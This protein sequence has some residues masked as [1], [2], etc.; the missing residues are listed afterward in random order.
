[1]VHGG[2]STVG[3]VLAAVVLALGLVT[4]CGGG[5]GGTS[6]GGGTPAPAVPS[7]KAG[8]ASFAD[9]AGL[10]PSAAVDDGAHVVFED[11]TGLAKAGA[12]R[13]D[14]SDPD[15]EGSEYTRALDELTKATGIGGV[16]FDGGRCGEC[17]PKAYAAD[18]RAA[19]GFDPLAADRA[20]LVGQ[21]PRELTLL[22]GGID[23]GALADAFEG[24]PTYAVVRTG[25]AV[26]IDSNCEPAR[27]RCVEAGTR[28][29]LG[30]GLHLWSDGA[31]TAI[32]FDPG[33]VTGVAD[34][35]TGKP[36]AEG[37]PADDPVRT[38]LGWADELELVSGAGSRPD[39]PGD[40]PLG[41][42]ADLP[43]A[44]GAPEAVAALLG[45]GP[46][47][48]G[49]GSTGAGGTSGGIRLVQ[50]VEVGSPAG[51]KTVSGLLERVY[52]DEVCPPSPP[53]A[54]VVDDVSVT[55]DGSVVTA[56]AVIIEPVGD[57]RDDPPPAN[58]SLWR[59]LWD[60][61]QVPYV[62]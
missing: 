3:G 6:A 2:R 20:V 12:S 30:R 17:Q 60:R 61:R 32:S 49:D 41:C 54:E 25:S 5:N 27:A 52:G 56:T 37:L 13:L 59:E 58:G 50:R 22:S 7:A 16:S 44:A 46:L 4:G 15:L 28:D 53:F 42:L 45:V 39:P 38:I 24:D 47:P 34:L 1:M 31:V 40:A 19:F 36:G 8:V 11:L 14:P 43:D 62:A 51:A 23:P 57:A 21:K 33:L 9:L 18:W 35:A 29:E 48:G 10:I 26:Q 55:T